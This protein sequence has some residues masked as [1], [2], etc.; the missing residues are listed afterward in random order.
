MQSMQVH[1][2]S[3]DAI[4]GVPRLPDAEEGFQMVW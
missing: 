3:K 1:E 2:A 4:L